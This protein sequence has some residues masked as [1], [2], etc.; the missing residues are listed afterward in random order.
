MSVPLPVTFAISAMPETPM[1]VQVF[2]Q[3]IADRL[4]ISGPDGIIFPS[5]GSVLPTS[6]IGPFLLNGLTWYVWDTISGSYIPEPLAPQSLKFVA[7]NAT[8]SPTD[9]IFW[10]YLDLT[11]KAQ[12]IRYYSG[13]AW[14]SIFEDKFAQY[15]TTAQM[16]T[17]IQAGFTRYPASAKMNSDQVLAVDG[18]YHKLLFNNEIS[19]PSSVYDFANS[20]YVAPINGIYHATCNSQVDNL[21][22]TSSGMEFGIQIVV[23]G[24]GGT[25]S[26]V[27]GTAVANPP[28]DRWYPQVDGWV[29]CSAGDKISVQMFAQDGVNTGS[30]QVSFNSQFFVYLVEPI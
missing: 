7:Q 12:D 16:N 30:V 25:N 9:Y 26:P 29:Q 24:F 21:T 5:T 23:N 13:G 3:A 6:D 1:N 15:S 8:P 28:G 22:G 2:A 4:S 17:A 20:W 19:D 14:K 27:S 10:I 18:S 11:G